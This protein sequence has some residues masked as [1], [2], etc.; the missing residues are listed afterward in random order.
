[1]FTE[2]QAG[3]IDACRFCFMCRHVCTLGVTTGNESDTPRGK[4]LILSRILQQYTGWNADLV[5][6]MYRCCLCGM[7]HAWCVGGYD[8]P[9]AVLAARR[10]IVEK[11]L[12]P[13]AARQ[14]RSNI[15]KTG[16]PFGLPAGDRFAR[17]TC[18]RPPKKDASV[19]YYVGCDTAYHQPEIANAFIAVLQ[20]AGVDFKLLPEETSTGKPLTVLGYADAARQIAEKLA[21]SIRKTGCTVLVTT[22]PASYD[23]FL[24]DYS[25]LLDG[26][27]ILHATEYAAR[28]IK[29]GR[30]KPS[31]AYPAAITPH[32]SDFLGRYNGIY[33][34]IRGILQSIQGVEVREMSWTRD[35][36]HSCGES[37]GVFSTLH[38][39]LGLMLAARLVDEA[40]HTGACVLATTC[41]VTKRTLAA[42]KPDG[43]EVRDVIEILAET[44]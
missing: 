30:L 16:N 28:L 10:D 35:K 40:K 32:D 20:R 17:V 21:E 3:T 41:P 15:E 1:M 5:E 8:M 43:I 34:P 36:A 38:P 24:K 29:E 18:P 22:C 11:G 31:K 6:S 23:A 14:M 37:A 4:G 2:S 12:E 44:L 42:A 13:A 9:S 25:G 33:D 27:E 39:E 19:V 26:I 7:C